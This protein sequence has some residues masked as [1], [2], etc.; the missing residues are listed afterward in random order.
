M[1][2]NPIFKVEKKEKNTLK[3]TNTLKESVIS[4][5]WNKFGSNEPPILDFPEPS[6]IDSFHEI[7]V[8]KFG[9]CL[10]RLFDWF[11]DFSK[12]AYISISELGS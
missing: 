2:Q 8:K 10:R 7:T 3:H 12:N 4:I 11:F 9:G 1:C 6:R 5:F